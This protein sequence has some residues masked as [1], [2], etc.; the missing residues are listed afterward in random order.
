MEIDVSRTLDGVLVTLHDRYGGYF[1]CLQWDYYSCNL[2]QKKLFKWEELQTKAEFVSFQSC[3]VPRFS[4]V[5]F[6]FSKLSHSRIDGEASE[7]FLIFLKGRD[8]QAMHGNPA[9]QVG[10]FT[11]SQVCSLLR[12]MLNK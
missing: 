1:V 7:P 5:S 2:L 12:Y 8:L 11:F 6:L 3:P 9:V 4:F 10:H